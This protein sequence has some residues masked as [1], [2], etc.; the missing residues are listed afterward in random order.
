MSLAHPT[1]RLIIIDAQLE[2]P[3]A[4]Q[5]AILNQCGDGAADPLLREAREVLGAQLTSAVALDVQR[6]S[7]A[8]KDTSITKVLA[9]QN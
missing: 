1:L 7:K 4:Q 8:M 9:S 6:L 3:V 2:R 5:L